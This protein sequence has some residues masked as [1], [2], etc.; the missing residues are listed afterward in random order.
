MEHKVEVENESSVTFV[1]K[2]FVFDPLPSD[3]S[4]G[5]FENE[6]GGVDLSSIDFMASGM[7]FTQVLDDLLDSDIGVE[8]DTNAA[9]YLETT[10]EEVIVPSTNTT[11]TN[12]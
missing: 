5:S 12:M 2:P 9:G 1:D 7:G 11:E 10:T 4:T 8:F 3:S 6:K